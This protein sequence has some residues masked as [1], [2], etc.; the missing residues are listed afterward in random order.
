MQAPWLLVVAACGGSA[1]PPALAPPP[2]VPTP[3]API[4]PH[5]RIVAR[6][7]AD[8]ALHELA[9]LDYEQPFKH[10]PWDRT[11][12]SKLFGDACQLG[13]KH[14]CIVEAQL[15]PL[16]DRGESY[17]TVE[18]NC[19]AGD[20][21]SCRALPLD[22]HAPRFPEAPGAMS[23]RVE[24]QDL[25]LP[26]PCDPQAL[27]AECSAGFPAA[28]GDIGF[29]FPPPPDADE[30]KDRWPQLSMEVCRGGI[31]SGCENVGG[32]RSD[33]VRFE[34]AQRLCELRPDDCGGLGLVY[35]SRKDRTQARDS[36]ERE[37]QYGG[38]Q[39][40]GTC[41]RLAGAYLD[42]T[43][44]EPVPGRAQALLDWACPQLAAELHSYLLRMHPACSHASNAAT[45]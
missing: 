31:A 11:A 10:K 39:R 6:A 43:L 22:D 18:A 16:D 12:T 13:D 24:C 35:E 42:G 23:R 41:A 17:H 1:P 37:C 44:E 29:S 4:D 45:K 40:A 27:R 20:L 9:P 28:C 14:A 19:L 25:H 33:S 32:L 26:A 2:A 30:L 36:F 7:R 34:M 3:A 8:A 15:V 38:H 5:A 21:M